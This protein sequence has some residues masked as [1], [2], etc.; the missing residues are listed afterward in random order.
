MTDW[1]KG[2]DEMRRA[3]RIG[4]TGDLSCVED[5]GEVAR[6]MGELRTQLAEATAVIARLR[7]IGLVAIG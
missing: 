7:A 3:K 5:L 2:A 1:R 6:E 4:H